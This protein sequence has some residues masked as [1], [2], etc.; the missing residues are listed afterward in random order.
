MDANRVRRL[1][2]I[3]GLVLSVFVWQ[4]CTRTYTRML[5]IHLEVLTYTA[6]KL[7]AVA[8]SPR[9]LRAEG[10]AEY[11]YPSQRAHEFLA[12]F[13]DDKGRTSYE[14]LVRFLEEYDALVRDAD[15]SR[16]VGRDSQTAVP[17]LEARRD[18]LIQLA[19]EIRADLKR[20]SGR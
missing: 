11:T 9:G 1:G 13:P 12:R 4:R 7:C 6:Q 14:K 17:E 5:P 16:A 3:L 8:A 15:A 18:A 2:I 10:I 19:Q 20:E